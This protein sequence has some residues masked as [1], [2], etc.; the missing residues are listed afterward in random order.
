MDGMNEEMAALKAQAEAAKAQEMMPVEEEAKPAMKARGVAAIRSAPVPSIQNATQ[1]WKEKIEK[2][3]SQG[4]DQV[5]A[6]RRVNRENPGL[7]A[8][9]L[10][11]RG[12]R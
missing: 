8:S 1:S 4:L 7:R 11:E 2:Y 9:M 10:S 12:I 6:V 5:A 3:V